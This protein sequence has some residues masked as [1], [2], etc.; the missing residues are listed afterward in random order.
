MAQTSDLVGEAPERKSSAKPHL[1]YCSRGRL[2]VPQAR[3]DKK[4]DATLF[5]VSPSHQPWWLPQGQDAL[6]EKALRVF[7]LLQCGDF[8]CQR[9]R[10]LFH[11]FKGAARLGQR[12]LLV[13]SKKKS[14]STISNAV[15]SKTTRLPSTVRGLNTIK[16]MA[17]KYCG[18]K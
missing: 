8:H 6:F 7:G 3:T 18:S 10:Y 15:F 16:K 4:A 12:D 14:D 17:E 5:R 9:K 1:H 2:R 11:A 13:V